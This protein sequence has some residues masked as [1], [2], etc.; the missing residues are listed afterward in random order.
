ME[1]RP[2]TPNVRR[3]FAAVFPIAVTTSAI[4]FAAGARDR[5]TQ[6]RVEDRERERAHDAD[7]A[8]RQRLVDD[9]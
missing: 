5:S 9:P 8:E 7:R 6:D 1:A 3:R 2:R 4:A